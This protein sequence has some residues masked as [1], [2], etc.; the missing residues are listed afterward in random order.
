MILRGFKL[1]VLQ[2]EED[3]ENFKAN[4]WSFKI[5]EGKPWLNRSYSVTF[6]SVQDSF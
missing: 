4:L 3:S 1:E 6:Y 2:K 5:K